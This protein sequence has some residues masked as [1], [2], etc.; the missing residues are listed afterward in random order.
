MAFQFQPVSVQSSICQASGQPLRSIVP[1][2]TDSA[3]ITISE[4]DNPPNAARC[5]YPVGG[6]KKGTRRVVSSKIRLVGNPASSLRL[7][8]QKKPTFPRSNPDPK[9]NAIGWMVTVLLNSVIA[10]TIFF[11]LALFGLIIGAPTVASIG[12]TGTII[13]A[14]GAISSFSVIELI[15]DTE[16]KRPPKQPR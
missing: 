6:V 3:E 11:F 2:P 4:R 12:F 9:G 8:V 7:R 14:A 1:L 13:A 5:K 16:T 10:L 15:M